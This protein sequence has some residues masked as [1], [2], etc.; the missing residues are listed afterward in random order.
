MSH[1]ELENWLHEA[2][3]S[4]LWEREGVESSVGMIRRDGLAFVV[5]GKVDG[6]S[7]HDAGTQ[8]MGPL[9]GAILHPAPRKAMVVGLGTGSSAGWLAAVESI[10]RVDVAEMEPAVLEVARQCAP[11]NRRALDSPKVHVTIGDG[12]ELLMTSRERYDLIFSEPSNPYRAGIAGLY[13]LDF[14][15]AVANRL[16]PGGIFSQWVQGYSVDPLTVRHIAA[17]LAAVFGNVETWETLPGDLLF[18]CSTGPKDFSLP[19]LAARIAT[20]PFRSALLAAWGVT[21]VDGFL[22]GF[23]TDDT[24]AR[25]ALRLAQREEGLNTDDL[26]PVEFGFAKS[27]GSNLMSMEAFRQDTRRRGAHR[28]AVSG[29]AV[30]WDRVDDNQLLHRVWM[31]A[32]WESRGTANA[33]WGSRGAAAAEAAYLAFQEGRCDLVRQTID[34]GTWKPAAPLEQVMAAFCFADA[35]DNRALVFLPEIDGIWPAAAATIRARLTLAQ[36][37]PAQALDPLAVAFASFRTD[38]W[39]PT[40]IVKA[41]MEMGSQIAEKHPELAERVFDLFDQPFSVRLQD[42]ARLSMLMNVAMAID[43]RHA[44]KVFP[45]FEPNVPWTQSILEYRLACYKATGN[46]LA[47]QA[48]EDLDR[49][50]AYETNP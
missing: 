12:R 15:R 33:G 42:K 11:V 28:P 37:G 27:L 1:N 20:E 29:G 2:R 23:F 5:N 45:Q 25:H 6:N 13:T 24:F 18:V 30:D 44:E 35:G 7:R 16:A 47:A 31:N 14:Y 9:V 46:P 50:M 22:A 17:T 26:A 32:G 38:P 36:R 39:S 4:V 3:F 49:Y 21:G 40:F 19:R 43:F 48:R 8:I 34:G 10:E 41:A